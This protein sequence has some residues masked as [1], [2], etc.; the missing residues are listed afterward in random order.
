M[1]PV[2][3]VDVAAESGR[4]GV[5]TGFIVGGVGIGRIAAGVAGIDT[6]DVGVSCPASRSVSRFARRGGTTTDGSRVNGPCIVSTGPTCFAAI[7]PGAIGFGRTPCDGAKPRLD[8]EG[9]SGDGIAGNCPDGA[10]GIGTRGAPACA[11][12]GC[13]G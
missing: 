13:S 1:P 2:G 12:R 9:S 6:G 8:C 5:G 4:A 11:G 10:D 7:E 3:V